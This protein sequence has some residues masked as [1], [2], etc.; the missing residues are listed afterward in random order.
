MAGR[1][2]TASDLPAAVPAAPAAAAPPAEP[3]VGGPGGQGVEAAPP[4]VAAAPPVVA[5]APTVVAAAPTVASVAP[6]GVPAVD[7]PARLPVVAPPKDRDPLWFAPVFVLAP[8]RSYSSVVTTM[9]GQHPDLYG[10]PELSLLRTQTVRQLLTDP[11]NWRGIPAMVKQAGLFRALAQV[12]EAEQTPESIARAVRW[13]RCRP[14]WNTLDV[15]DHLL[16]AVAPRIGIEKSPETV[17]RLAYMER[18][19]TAYPRAR[20]VHLVRHPLTTQRSMVLAWK[21]RNFWDIEP[22]MFGQFCLGVWYHQHR[23]IM[24]FCARF[25]P[26]RVWRIRSEDA[27]NAPQK[28]FA[29]F[30]RWLGIDGS[31]AALAAMAHPERDPFASRGPQGAAG[32]NDPAFLRD[33]SRRRATL[34]RSL[35]LTREFVVDPW[36]AVAAMELAH[37]FGYGAEPPAGPVA[38]ALARIQPSD[39]AGE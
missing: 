38:A 9:I 20:F 27:L 18:L 32:G 15:Y 29:P 23:R 39:D 24:E 2:R 36:S 12:N 16:G 17:S 5:A 11:P 28:T 10:F 13:L 26:D 35:E 4:V 1:A 3:P 25:P 21:D 6:A 19:A 34:P 31:R 37:Q 30:C 8:A 33:P 22:E 14:E 7:A